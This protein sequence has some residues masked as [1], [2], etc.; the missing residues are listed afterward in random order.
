MKMSNIIHTVLTTPSL[1]LHML[2]LSPSPSPSTLMLPTD[3]RLHIHTPY[4]RNTHSTRSTHSTRNIRSTC[5]THKLPHSTHTPSSP[6]PSILTLLTRSTPSST[7]STPSS[8]LSTPSSTLS[9]PSHLPSTNSTH[10]PHSP[11]TLTN[12]THSIL[13]S[14]HTDTPLRNTLTLST[15]MARP[16]K[17]PTPNIHTPSILNTLSTHTTL[18]IHVTRRRIIVEDQPEDPH[19]AVTAPLRTRMTMRAF[20]RNLCCDNQSSN[21]VLREIQSLE[22]HSHAMMLK[23]YPT[24]HLL[25]PLNQH[26]A[27]GP[28]F[29]FW[30]RGGGTQVCRSCRE[31]DS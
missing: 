20:G 4:I 18:N 7:L 5:S 10:D 2:S 22:E 24:K 11:N 8:T 6:N 27:M 23:H 28:L 29:I 13:H 12:S 30:G 31:I 16:S 19:T 1:S 26:S 21:V 3:S 17:D 14:T 9:T 15:H 25:P